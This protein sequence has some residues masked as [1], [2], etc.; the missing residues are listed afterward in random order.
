MSESMSSLATTAYK[1]TGIIPPRVEIVSMLEVGIDL[2]D[3][4][5]FRP[6]ACFSNAYLLSL[7]VP[8]AEYVE[9]EVLFNGLSIIH[10]WN[11]FQEKHF[12]ITYELFSPTEVKA[13]HFV[14]V[15]GLTSDLEEQGYKLNHHIDLF[16]QKLNKEKRV[17]KRNPW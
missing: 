15:Q 6:K 7:L 12:D 4:D 9:G 8:G 2:V 11:Y 5:V 13:P 3:L 16:T 10:A 14:F 1:L 17:T